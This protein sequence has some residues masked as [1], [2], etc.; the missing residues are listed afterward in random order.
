VL[1]AYEKVLLD[2]IL[3]DH[4]LFWRQ[5]AVEEAWRVLTPVLN[6]CEQCRGREQKLIMYP[7]GSWGPETARP[8][9]DK[10]RSTTHVS[11]VGR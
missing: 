6:E 11:P 10:I 1:D 4:M 9:I 3:G 7:A 2:C 8:W 5:D